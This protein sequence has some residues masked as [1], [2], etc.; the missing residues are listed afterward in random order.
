MD[1]HG[2]MVDQEKI[3]ELSGVEMLDKAA[4]EILKFAGDI[5]VFAFYGEMG[6]GKTTLIRHICSRLGVIDNV[7]SPTF[8]LINEYNTSGGEILYH[9]DF[10]RIKTESEAFDLGYEDYFYSERYCFIEWPVKVQ[11]LLPESI[12][13]VN[14]QIK[15]NNR[16]VTLKK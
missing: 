6:A 2:F 10:Y 11:N 5:K 14:I 8:T 15:G 7:N 13:E 3:F 9:F 4:S 1:V 12:I 16:L